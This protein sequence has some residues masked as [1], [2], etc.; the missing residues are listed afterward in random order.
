MQSI[1]AN[2]KLA[3]SGGQ[4]EPR[5]AISGTVWALLTHP[6]QLALLAQGKAKW[7]DAFEE[8]ARWIA[9]I[10]MSPRRVARPW[11]YGGVD[12]EPEDRVFFMFGSANRDEACFPDPDRFDIT[13]DTAKSIAFGAGPHYCAGAFASRAMVADVALPSLFKRLRNPR[14]DQ[15][16]PVRIGGWAFRG[17]LN[18]PVIWDR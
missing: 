12:F 5:D 11:S 18:L 10:G 15:S 14:L 4:N 16:E 8:Y 3:I 17:L 7:L 2:I 13:R 1:R 6:D 9:P